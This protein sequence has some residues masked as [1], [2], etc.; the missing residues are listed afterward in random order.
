VQDLEARL[1]K[2]LIDAEDCALIAKL[3][4]DGEKRSL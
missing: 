4:T 3:T 1:E 2:L